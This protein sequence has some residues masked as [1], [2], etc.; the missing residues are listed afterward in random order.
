MDAE[1]WQKVQTSGLWVFA[2][3]QSKS[4]WALRPQALE[5]PSPRTAHV[6]KIGLSEGCCKQNLGNLKVITSGH[7]P[8]RVSAMVRTHRSMPSRTPSWH[9][10]V[11]TI[12]TGHTACANFLR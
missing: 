12:S 2:P 1:S 9:R 7:G 11:L 5:H 4:A 8:L 3:R 10:L 6:A